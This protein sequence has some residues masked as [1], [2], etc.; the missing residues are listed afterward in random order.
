MVSLYELQCQ[1]GEFVGCVSSGGAFSCGCHELMSG[2]DVKFNSNEGVDVSEGVNEEVFGR[3]MNVAERAV[4]PFSKVRTPHCT[5]AGMH[6]MCCSCG[7]KSCCFCA[8][9]GA[10]C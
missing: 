5:K 7:R 6:L 1:D 8:G 10:R 4:F 3:G 2:G 9:T